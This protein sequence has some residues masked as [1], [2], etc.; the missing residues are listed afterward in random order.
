VATL[1]LEQL[2]A[3][4]QGIR[5]RR[6]RL[7]GA[8]KELAGSCLAIEPVGFRECSIGARVGG[9]RFACC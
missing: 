5:D 2:A 6:R 3:A 1:N 8:A 9:L 4:V 7:V